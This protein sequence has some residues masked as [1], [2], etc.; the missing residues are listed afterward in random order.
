MDNTS[1][2]T[3]DMQEQGP[4]KGIVIIVIS[5]LLG[6][7]GLLLW[8]FFEKKSNLD[9]ANQTIITTSAE[10]DA[11]RTQ[12]TQIQVEY[13]K[14]KAENTDLQTQL[15]T[16]DEEIK[17]KVAQIQ[18]LIAMGGPAQIARA[19]AEMA[20]LK[21]MSILYQ[22]NVDSLNKVNA[23]LQA[24]NKNL[25][26]N[27]DKEQ[28]KN[29]NLSAENSKLAT[30][31]AAGSVLKAMNIA[32]EGLYSKS[33]GK[34]V[35]TNKAKKVGMMRTKFLL[36][37]NKVVDKGELDLYLR[38]LGPDGGVMTADH[39][40]FSANGETLEYTKKES[41]DYNNEDTPVQIVWAKG[42]QFAKGKYTVE[43]YC[44]GKVIGKSTAELK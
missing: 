10:K 43:V 23:T 39:A 32:T 19:K 36:T 17:E 24:E 15:S 22:V 35:I 18:R 9:L 28:S 34:E 33:S 11:L 37:E 20:R 41:V 30:K 16:K 38:V 8:Q 31:I 7:N 42:T 25:N 3:D 21:E 13:E 4:R 1:A 12:L 26:T 14:M 29:Q 2:N 6:T 27:L 44:G 40:T 5:I